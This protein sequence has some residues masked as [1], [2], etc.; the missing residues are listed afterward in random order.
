MYFAVVTPDA[1]LIGCKD[2]LEA[3]VAT[4]KMIREARLLDGSVV[5]PDREPAKHVPLFVRDA[6]AAILP[7]QA[8]IK[9]HVN[10]RF[11][12]LWH[13][14]GIEFPWLDFH[15]YAA[16]AAL[17]QLSHALLTEMANDANASI[18]ALTA[19]S[20]GAP[21]A[22]PQMHFTFMHARDRFA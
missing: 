22:T 9:Q 14:E 12:L 19:G 1:R 15:G 10:A 13:M 8:C 4:Q 20:A 18:S 2:C 21:A 6:R 16:P 3:T 17:G 5:W 11:V 7:K